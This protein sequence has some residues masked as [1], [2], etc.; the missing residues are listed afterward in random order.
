MKDV[1]SSL[2]DFSKKKKLFLALGIL[3]GVLCLTGILLVFFLHPRN[4]AYLY[5]GISA[6]LLLIWILGDYYFLFYK[7]GHIR[8]I[9]SF[10]KKTKKID[11]K[12]IYTFLK[13]DGVSYSNKLGFKKLVFLSKDNKEMIFLVL[14]ESTCSFEENHQYELSYRKDYLLGYEGKQNDAKE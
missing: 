3:L 1:Y 2:P 5:F 7:L 8:A 12:D 14:M 6:G 13:E 11:G 10:L 9:T 4:D